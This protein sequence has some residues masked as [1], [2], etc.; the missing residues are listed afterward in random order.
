[1]VCPKAPESAK[2]RV[3]IRIQFFA[4]NFVNSNTSR[5][6]CQNDNY[7]SIKQLHPLFKDPKAMTVSRPR[8]L[9]G[10]PN[11]GE[12]LSSSE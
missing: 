9:L 10:R 12:M 3:R 5:N 1:M 6:E 11:F 4:E 7:K 8:K 2:I